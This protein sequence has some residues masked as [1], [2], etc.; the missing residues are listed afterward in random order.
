MIKRFALCT[1]AL[2]G[3]LQASPALAQSAQTLTAT[4]E[5]DEYSDGLGSVR[6]IKLEYKRVDEGTTV[7]F[8]PAVGERRAA[9]FSATAVGGGAAIY[10]DWSPTV[11]TRMS[12]FFAENEPVFANEDL[13]L[14]VT[15]KV[16]QNTTATVGGRYARYF[17]GVDVVFASAGIRQYFRFG[18]V[19]YR[20]TRVDPEGR[21]AYFAHLFNLSVKDGKGDGRTQLWLSA[22]DASYSSVHMPAGF[23]GK[24]YGVNV[25]RV[26]PIGGKVNLVPS[27]GYTSYARPGDRVSAV[28]LGLGVSMGLD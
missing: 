4:A 26:Q 22:G 9:G 2:A 20:L 28:N 14:D 1:A 8:T 21:R 19:A 12:A 24:D 13:A 17:G 15:A 25:Q 7:V 10:H 27:L 5:S 18:S 6:S 3:V 23:S 16:A 11:S